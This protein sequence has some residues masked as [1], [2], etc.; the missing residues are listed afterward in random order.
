MLSD[1]GVL[2]ETGALVVQTWE[3]DKHVTEESKFLFKTVDG[4]FALLTALAVDLHV[5]DWSALQLYP[6]MA[7][8]TEMRNAGPL[9]LGQSLEANGVAPGATLQLVETV[10]VTVVDCR[11]GL[12]SLR[13]NQVIAADRRCQL[14]KL[15]QE[16]CTGWGL[17]MGSVRLE[18][19]GKDGTPQ[20]TLQDLLSNET[21]EPSSVKVN[22]SLCSL[23]V[24]FG[25]HGTTVG[26][27]VARC[28][29]TLATN[30]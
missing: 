12:S 19:N 20:S 14:K 9:R 27:R 24:A 6:C 3:G 10:A 21:L 17:P 8:T 25:I 30:E 2:S 13:R 4:L 23:H 28:V 15:L 11:D 5:V 29:C 26:F 1:T 18:C 7:D 16:L 22:T